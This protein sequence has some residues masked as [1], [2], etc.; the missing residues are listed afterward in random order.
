[1]EEKSFNI[2][3]AKPE[4]CAAVM[5]MITELAAFGK[6]EDKVENTTEGLKKDI[7]DSD[8]LASC[9]VA[10]YKRPGNDKSEVIGYSVFYYAYS[11]MKGKGVF[12]EDLYIMEEFRGRGYGRSLMKRVAQIALE[13]GCQRM[14]WEVL[15]WNKPAIK[16]YES[17]NSTDLTATEDWHK[18][19]L[20]KE[21]FLQFA[22]N[23]LYLIYCFGAIKAHKIMEEERFNIREA[24]PE[25]CAAVMRMITELAV[26]ENAEKEVQNTTEGL[27]KDI[28]D[29]GGLV[30]CLVAEYK[31]PENETSE[32]IGYSIFFYTYSTWKGKVVYMED[33]YIMKEFRG[34]GYGRSLMKRVAQTGVEKGCQRMQWAVLGWNKPA[35]KLYESLNSTD[36]T[37]TEDWH[38]ITLF[39]E[40]FLQF[41]NN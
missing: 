22:N 39:K 35:I 38:M 4:D 29:S 15:G 5:R 14:Q 34:R 3:D 11:T 23:C 12:M 20:S 40:Q 41:A 2:R 13:K 19:V 37:A 1:M 25:D 26:F 6:R 32:V 36:L 17:V 24:M 30:S 33:L 18:I 28:F 8:G 21:Y 31:R 10:E 9:L 7:F 16:L 27:K